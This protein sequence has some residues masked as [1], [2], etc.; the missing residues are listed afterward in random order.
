[1]RQ[2]EQLLTMQEIYLSIQSG[3]IAMLRF[4][5]E[6]YEGLAILT[7]LDQRTG[8]V[9]LLCPTTRVREL[10]DLLAALASQLACQP[11]PD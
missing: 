10:W 7:T 8:L 11:L 6:G 2:P 4:I 9:R 3:Q 5:L 1:M